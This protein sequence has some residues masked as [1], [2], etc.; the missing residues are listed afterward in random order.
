MFSKEFEISC[1]LECTI[2]PVKSFYNNQILFY[3][4]LRRAAD[5]DLFASLGIKKLTYPLLWE[6]VVLH[7]ME[8]MNRK[9]IDSRMKCIHELDIKPIAGLLHYGSRSNYLLCWRITPSR[10]PSGI[11]DLVGTCSAPHS[12]NHPHAKFYLPYHTELA[13]GMFANDTL[14]EHKTQEL[15]AVQVHL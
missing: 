10:P 8:E 5:L 11:Q 2:N 12:E 1:G 7:F 13:A 4:H 9:G 3:D 6:T 14:P 15:Q